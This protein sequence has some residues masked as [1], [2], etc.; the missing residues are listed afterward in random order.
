M[1]Y[2]ED[3]FN[4]ESDLSIEDDLNI[5]SDFDVTQDEPKFKT[6]SSDTFENYQKMYGNQNHFEPYNTDTYNDFYDFLENHKQKFFYEKTKKISPDEVIKDLPTFFKEYASES[7]RVMLNWVVGLSI[8]SAFFFTL[9]ARIISMNGLNIISIFFV[10]DSI[11]CIVLSLITVKTK[12]WIFSFVLSLETIVFIAL[13]F[14]L[15][16]IILQGAIFFL[17]IFLSFVIARLVFSILTFQRLKLLEKAH[18]LHLD[19]LENPEFDI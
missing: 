12:K 5:E 18:K 1:D 10:L 13:C 2:N 15:G 11:L 9:L 16:A 17:L 8:V 19:I 6:F 4:K 3:A 7:T 14:S